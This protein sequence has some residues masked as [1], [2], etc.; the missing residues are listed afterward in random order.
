MSIVQQGGG[1]CGTW[2]WPTWHDPRWHRWHLTLSL[3]DDLVYKSRL[4]L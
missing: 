2:V 1:V 4:R 3:R